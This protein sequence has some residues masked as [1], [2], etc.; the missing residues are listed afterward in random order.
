MF[1]FIRFRSGIN[2]INIDLVLF[3]ANFSVTHN[4][5][6]N[7]VVLSLYFDVFHSVLAVFQAHCMYNISPTYYS[8]IK[9]IDFINNTFFLNSNHKNTLILYLT[10]L[11]KKQKKLNIFIK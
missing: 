4:H 10:I 7:L 9:T 8:K 5:Y 3:F 2:I 1:E 6:R 11:V